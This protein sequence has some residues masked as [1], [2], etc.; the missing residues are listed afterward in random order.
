MGK[1][2]GLRMV[3]MAL[4]LA[5]AGAQSQE[6]ANNVS[7]KVDASGRIRIGYYPKAFAG[8]Q[9]TD[10]KKIESSL[11]QWLLSQNSKLTAENFELRNVRESLTAKHFYF[12]QKQDGLVVESAEVIVSVDNSTQ[13]MYRIFDNSTESKPAVAKA[14]SQ[15]TSEK[16]VDIAWKH[17]WVSGR[18]LAD[19]KSEKLF[20]EQDGTLRL[21]YRVEIDT[22]EPAGSWE[23]ILDAYTG[24]IVRTQD[25]RKDAK[26]DD[27]K[28]VFGRTPGKKLL[29]YRE[30]VKA[31]DAKKS[32]SLKKIY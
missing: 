25:L 14:G 19:V 20:I 10:L 9:L 22:V 32:I 31:L 16:A 15:L 26:H 17:I 2:L 21:T 8:K 29:D 28:P 18:L 1:L 23:V 27:S 11:S 24:E 6:G 7:D 30:A 4:L 5:G 13:E 12:Q 3:V